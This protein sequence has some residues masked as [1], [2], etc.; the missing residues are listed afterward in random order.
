MPKLSPGAQRGYWRT[1][2]P[3]QAGHCLPTLVASVG[4]GRFSLQTAM[5]SA[6]AFAAFRSHQKSRGLDYFLVRRAR[7]RDGLCPAAEVS[8]EP[9]KGL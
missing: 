5:C 6:G 3:L 4:G 1:G 9:A 2:A 7:G 8:L